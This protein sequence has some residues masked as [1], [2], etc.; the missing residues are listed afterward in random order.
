MNN[1][2]FARA[3][4]KTI[5]KQFAASEILKIREDYWFWDS[6]RGTNMLPLMTKNSATGAQGASNY[7]PGEFS[8]IDYTPDII[9]EWFEDEIFP[10]MGTRTRIMA[11]LTQPGTANIEHI[12]CDLDQVGTQQ[13]KFRIVL[14]GRTGTLY[15]KT[16]A[17]DVHVPDINEA[18]IMDGG[19]PHG[20][21][22]DTD[23]L[24]LTIAAGA[25]WTGKDSYDNIDVLM[26]RAEHALPEDLTPYLKS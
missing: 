4:F 25:P 14:Q 16:T 8:W 20:M 15:Y 13:H 24:K 19:W 6:Y 7:R 2:L 26:N 22:N 1:I 11:L 9:R 17:G 23:Q 21:I 18:F 10:W 12:D 5:D 3:N